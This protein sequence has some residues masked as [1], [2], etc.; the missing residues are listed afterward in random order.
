MARPPRPQ[1]SERLR[2]LREQAGL[3]QESLSAKAGVP[4]GTL[5]NYE[6]GLRQPSW[7]T[8]VRLTAA[9]GVTSAEFVDCR[10]LAGG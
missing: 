10:E 8:F 1:F 6:Q 5:R 4:I 7:V 2:S 9:L 3:T